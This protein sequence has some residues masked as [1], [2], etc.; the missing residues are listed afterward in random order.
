MRYKNNP[1]NIRYSDSNRW[2]GQ[3]APKNGFC[4][5]EDI[6]Y[7]IRALCIVLRTYIRKYNLTSV[8]QIISTFAPE[9]ENNTPAYIAYVS[10]FLAGR[11]CVS[12]GITF[13]SK[14]FCVL[15]CAIMW[16]ETN[17]A[18]SRVRVE[19]VINMFNLQNS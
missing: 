10:R 7:G 8:P 14:D 15:C 9:Y 13:G 18:C 1:A 12:T 17:F 19:N 6:S 11:D 16:Y 5:F 4:Q 3:I 2:L